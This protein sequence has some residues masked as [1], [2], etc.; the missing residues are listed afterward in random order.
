[1]GENLEHGEW[2]IRSYPERDGHHWH[3]WAAVA[4]RSLDAAHDDEMFTFSDIGYFDTEN[5]A[6]DRG[7][8]W[9]KAWLDSNF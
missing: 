4:R 7:I 3:S 9:A 5:E 2:V 8:A 1:M 6:R